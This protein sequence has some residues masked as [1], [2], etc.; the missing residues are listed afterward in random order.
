MTVFCFCFAA[1]SQQNE[2]KFK[3]NTTISNRL[4]KNEVEADEELE[5]NQAVGLEG[6]ELQAFESAKNEFKFQYQLLHKQAAKKSFSSE[7]QKVL[8]QQLA[9]MGE[10][11]KSTFEYNFFTYLAG[12]YD[13]ANFQ[14]LE[15][16]AFLAPNNPEVWEEMLAYYHIIGNT[17][18]ENEFLKLLEKKN[19]YDASLLAYAEDVLISAQGGILLT[20]G[21]KDTYPLLLAKKKLGL[22][23]EIIN[24]D[25][26]TSKTYREALAQKNF[27]LPEG[28]FVNTV[29]VKMFLSLNKERQLQVAMTLPSDYLSLLDQQLSTKG[30]TYSYAQPLNV[31]ENEK[32]WKSLYK[33][34]LSKE[35][36]MA[37][38][39]SANYIP[40]LK[41]L[42]KAEKNLSAK[43]AYKQKVEAILQGINR[44]D[45][46]NKLLEIEE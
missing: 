35:D 18:K 29:Y 31:K 9:V 33:S 37:Q 1:F 12:N 38:R 25:F 28:A 4:E 11:G 3:N 36:Q 42:Y 40:L 22:E 16:A 13:T 30:L 46:L 34:I 19:V 17:A 32:I 45:Q 41:V 14:F 44:E 15:K 5:S 21:E 20:H 27:V 10:Y 23:A 2:E 6:S 26:L 43:E 39:L 7:E 24:I 8:N